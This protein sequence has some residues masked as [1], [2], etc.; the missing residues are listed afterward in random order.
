MA[1]G[2]C[3]ICKR[4]PA[5]FRAQV[6]V[7]GERQMME[8]CDEDYRKLARQQRRSGSPL[9]SLFGGSSLL[10]EFFGDSPFGGMERRFGESEGQRIPVNRGSRRGQGSRPRAKNL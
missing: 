6:S 4:R 2:I 1:N 8:L 3:D 9:E 5:S 7:N 10:D